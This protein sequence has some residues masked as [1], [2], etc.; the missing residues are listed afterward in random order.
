MAK[1]NR[2]WRGKIETREHAERVVRLAAGAFGVVTG[3][4]ALS[5][6]N[7]IDIGTIILLMIFGGLSLSLHRGQNVWAARGL[8]AI[9]GLGLAL[10]ATVVALSIQDTLESALYAVMLFVALVWGLGVAAAMRAHSATLFLRSQRRARG[11]A[12]IEPAQ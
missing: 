4:I 2:F 11:A 6:I 9:C 1:E 12:A 10:T 3:L 7:G 8:I 5:L